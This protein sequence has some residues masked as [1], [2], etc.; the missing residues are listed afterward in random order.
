MTIQ[1][2]I[3]QKGKSIES[4]IDMSSLHSGL[5]LIQLRF[6]NGEEETQKIVKK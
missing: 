4:G 1:G 5:Y 6:E 3:L 2:T